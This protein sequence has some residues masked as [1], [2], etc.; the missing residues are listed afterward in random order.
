MQRTTLS[1]LIPPLAVCRYGCAGCCAAPI[2]VFW[3]AGI[4]SII[5]GYLGGPAGLETASWTTIALGIGLWLIASVWARMAIRGVNDDECQRKRSTVC[6]M[7]TPQD[8]DSDP[9]EDIKKFSSR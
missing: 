6:R 8:K 4:V 7:V 9:L 3:L 2:G 5:Y 1:I